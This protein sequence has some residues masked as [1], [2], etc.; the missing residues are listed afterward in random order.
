MISIIIII[1]VVVAVVFVAADVVVLKKKINKTPFPHRTL[2]EGGDSPEMIAVA[3][4]LG[5]PHPPGYP[6]FSLLTKVSLE[7]VLLEERKNAPWCRG[8][9]YCVEWVQ[10]VM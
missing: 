10:D 7:N 6:T 4:V 5:V 3:H 8:Y 2:R 9:H 1:V